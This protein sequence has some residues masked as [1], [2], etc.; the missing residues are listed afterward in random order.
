MKEYPTFDNIKVPRFN[1]AAGFYTTPKRSALMS[2]IKSKNTKPEIKLRKTLW[3][4]GVRYRLNVKKLPGT[5]D[6]VVR[7]HKLVIFVDGEFWHG[8]DWKEKKGKIKSN[9]AFWIPKIERNM[10]RDRQNNDILEKQGWTVF[11][12]WEYQIK[13]EFG[14]CINKIIEHIEDCKHNP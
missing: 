11:R 8:F 3:H 4:A 5:P 14:A 10:Q 1:E 9:R 7:K 12:F 6:I 13:K 2:K